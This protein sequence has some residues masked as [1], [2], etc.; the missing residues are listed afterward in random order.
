MIPCYI[1]GKK[2]RVKPERGVHG[3]CIKKML[4][5]KEI[6]AT[7]LEL[8]DVVSAQAISR[9]AENLD[10]QMK[11]ISLKLMTRLDQASVWVDLNRKTKKLLLAE[12]EGKFLLKSGSVNFPGLTENEHICMSIAALLRIP[13]AYHALMRLHNN[14]VALLVRRFDVENRDTSTYRTA[15]EIL[16]KSGIYDGDL[17]EIGK[18][19]FQVS[20][21]PGLDVQLFFEMVL[22]AFILGD[23]DLHFARFS[24]VY[25]RG[26]EPGQEVVRLS[27]LGG[28]MS[29]KLVLPDEDDFMMTMLGKGNFLRGR[30]FSNF[31]AHLG[32]HAKAYNKIVLRFFKGKRL[33]GRLIRQSSLPMETKIRF[34][35][36]IDERFK[37]LFS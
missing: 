26:E 1:C 25:R 4:G 30:D 23:N 29:R 34:S 20:E 32:I 33:I 9:G 14:G 13:V 35:D 27:W 22:L 3:V 19:V 17:L 15:A 11:P 7:D 8:L 2:I 6:P 37:R 31:A 18:L 24:L 10:N 5:M 21:F 12:G 28:M 36:I 16:G